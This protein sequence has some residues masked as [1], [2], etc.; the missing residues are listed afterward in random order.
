MGEVYFE[1]TEN[2]DANHREQDE[3]GLN[4]PHRA[5]DG[6]DERTKQEGTSKD[7]KNEGHAQP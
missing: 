1:W 2:S 3:D 5:N 6:G 7:E 4:L